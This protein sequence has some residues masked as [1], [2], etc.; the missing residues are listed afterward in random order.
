MPLLCG[1]LLAVEA[2]RQLALKAVDYTFASEA[3][4]ELLRARI[5]S[6]SVS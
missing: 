5:S 2:L 1:G 3:E 4:K 6:A